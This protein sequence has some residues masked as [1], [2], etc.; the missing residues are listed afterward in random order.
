MVLLE[1]AEGSLS[2]G[3]VENFRWH[4]ERPGESPTVDLIINAERKGWVTLHEI[5]DEADD[6]VIVRPSLTSVGQRRIAELNQA[7]VQPARAV[8]ADDHL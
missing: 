7:G 2:M 4:A 8:D 3:R 5:L 6:R 1:C